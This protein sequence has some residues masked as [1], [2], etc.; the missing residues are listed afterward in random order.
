[1]KF[2]AMVSIVLGVMILLNLGGIQT[3]A[4]GGLAKA[5]G[6]VSNQNL[7]PQNFKNSSPWGTLIYLL[8]GGVTAGVV[9]GA[10][11]RAPDIRYLT[12]AIVGTITALMASDLIFIITLLISNSN[13]LAIGIGLLGV[14]LL[15]GLLITALEFWQGTD[16]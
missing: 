3:P 16:N 9:L 15:G 14:V 2:Y 7:T 4:T 11:G 1:M 10:F 12:A 5:L 13:P 6:L 8:A